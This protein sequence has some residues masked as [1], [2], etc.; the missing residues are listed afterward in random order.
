MGFNTKFYQTLKNSRIIKAEFFCRLRKET[1]FRHSGDG[2][3]L[4]D[5]ECLILINNYVG[6]G[7]LAY[8]LGCQSFSFAEVAVTKEITGRL[9]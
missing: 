7:A 6:T 3:R 5:I 4:Q 1:C 2:V 8:P 9:I